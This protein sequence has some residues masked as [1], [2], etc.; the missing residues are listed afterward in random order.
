MRGS[1]FSLRFI[2]ALIRLVN[3]WLERGAIISMDN[4]YIRVFNL[5]CFSSC[6]RPAIIVCDYCPAIRFRSLFAI[7]NRGFL[8]R[9]VLSCRFRD[10]VF[11]FLFL[12]FLQ[13]T[14]FSARFLRSGWVNCSDLWRKLVGNKIWNQYSKVIEV[15]NVG[16]V[17]VDLE[18]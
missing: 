12:L 3:R 2:D 9:F 10:F 18:K 17:F 1:R 11:F 7:F 4:L 14:V 13:Y 6:I 15:F 16:F 5:I 8:S